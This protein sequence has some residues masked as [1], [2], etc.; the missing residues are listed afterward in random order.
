MSA[1]SS[2]FQGISGAVGDLGLG[3]QLQGQVQNETEEERKRRLAQMQQQQQMGP[4]G[5]MAV[6]AL[7]GPRGGLPN[8]PG[9]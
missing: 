1:L 3:G 2:E 7:F 6:T 4:A 8:A 5:S 9:Y